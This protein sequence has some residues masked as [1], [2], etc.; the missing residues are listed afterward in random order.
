MAK[1][2]ADANKEY[3][4]TC[5]YWDGDREIEFIAGKPKYIK[6]EGGANPRC[7][8]VRTTRYATSGINCRSYK[9]WNAI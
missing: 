7:P 6:Y 2:R 4:A 5:Q 1:V 9:R 8:A 3:C